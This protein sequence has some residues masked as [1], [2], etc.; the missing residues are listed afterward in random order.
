MT[1]ANLR[2]SIKLRRQ[3]AL[4]TVGFLTV[5]FGDVHLRVQDKT[6]FRFRGIFPWSAARR[7]K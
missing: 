6:V 1:I 3:L 7:K 2:E 5:W 4:G